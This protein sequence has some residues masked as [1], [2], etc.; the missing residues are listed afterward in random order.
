MFN[1]FKKNKVVYHLTAPISGHTMSLEQVKD[2]V[3]AQKMMGDGIAIKS[4]GDV[5]VAPADGEICLFPKTKHAIG[6]KLENGVE[7]LIHIGLDSVELKGEGFTQLVEVGTHV[8]MGTPLLKIDRPF[9]ESKG[10]TLD[11]PMIIVNYTDYEILA[12]HHDM[13]VIAG[14]SVVVEYR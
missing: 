1:L 8:P 12:Y 3:F 2:P 13:D 7:V 11:T 14:E 6:L 4:T 9:V 5:V 10:V